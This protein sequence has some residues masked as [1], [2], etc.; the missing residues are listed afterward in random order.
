MKRLLR[1][2]RPRCFST[3]GLR[4]AEWN[5]QPISPIFDKLKPLGGGSVTVGISPLH[6]KLAEITISNPSS[7]N[8]LS[9]KMMT[10]FLEVVQTLKTDNEFKETVAVCVKGEDGTGFCSGADLSVL[11]DS[12]TK[13]D[14]VLMCHFMQYTLYGL[15]NLPQVSVAAIERF[16]V[17]GGTELSLSCDFRVFSHNSWFHMVQTKMGLTT[18]WGGG[19]RLTKLVG[20]QKA[21]ALLPGGRRMTAEECLRNGIADK[22]CSE[23]ESLSDGTLEFL[24]PYLSASYSDSVR[25]SKCVVAEADDLPMKEALEIEAKY[26]KSLWGGESNTDALS[27]VLTKKK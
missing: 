19:S 23:G 11:K 9:G 22:V 14:G 8:A 27:R 26:F 17:G 20:R 3:F 15:R 7:K 25:A 13:E 12:F 21:L 2:P 1:F 18:G 6:P 10:E 16:A 24:Q 5:G 4:N